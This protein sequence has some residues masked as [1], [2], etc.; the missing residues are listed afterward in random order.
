[1]EKQRERRIFVKNNWIMSNEERIKYLE[2]RINDLSESHS[3][4]SL[5]LSIVTIGFLLL[6]VK[7][8]MSTL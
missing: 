6:A 1:M 4:Q 2:K 7:V 8:L 3:R 5:S